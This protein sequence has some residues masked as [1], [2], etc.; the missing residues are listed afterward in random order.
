MENSIFFINVS[1]RVLEC[2]INGPE[3]SP[4]ILGGPIN[5][6]TI[7]LG[8]FGGHSTCPTVG[9]SFLVFV[10]KVSRESG[11]ELLTRGI[12]FMQIVKTPNTLLANI[13]CD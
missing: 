10:L 11:V 1:A 9:L 7:F 3:V 2:S 13:A 12:K 4:R 5:S 8:V 6:T